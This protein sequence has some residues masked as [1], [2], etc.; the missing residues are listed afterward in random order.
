MVSD[1]IPARPPRRRRP[2]TI[3]VILAGLALAG[4][5]AWLVIRR[6]PVPPPAAGIPKSLADERHAGDL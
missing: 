5:A 4:A 6:P 1:V 3:G 2:L